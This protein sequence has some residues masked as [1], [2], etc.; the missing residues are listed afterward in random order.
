MRAWLCARARGTPACCWSGG[1]GRGSLRAC[2]KPPPSR[3]HVPTPPPPP[4]P[5]RRRR[6]PPPLPA[7]APRRS[8]LGFVDLYGTSFAEDYAATGYGNHLAMPLIRDRCVA[9]RLRD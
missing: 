1:G 7:A 2:F 3:T 5:R 4:P 8:Y 9:H 6:S